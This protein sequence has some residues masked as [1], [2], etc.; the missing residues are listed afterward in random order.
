MYTCHILLTLIQDEM[1]SL[2][3]TQDRLQENNHKLTAMLTE[4]DQQQVRHVF[5]AIF[6]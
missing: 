3:Q 4:M 6:T 2:K 5:V 1:K